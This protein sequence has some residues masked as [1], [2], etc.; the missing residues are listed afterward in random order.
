M[1]SPSAPPLTEP[2]TVVIDADRP[3]AGVS[4]AELWRYRDLLVILA[5]RDLQ[6]RYRQA[7]I[8][9]GWAVLR[10]AATVAIFV[11]F[12]G[13]LGKLPASGT[14]SYAASALVGFLSWQLVAATISHLSD[15]LVNN[16]HVLTKVYFPRVLI[17][18]S[19]VSVGLVDYLVALIPTVG[20]LVFLGVRS[21][22]PL[23]FAPLWLA[24]LLSAAIGTGLL[25]SALNA[26]YRDIGQLVPFLLQL[27]FFL[28]PVVYE[29][30]AIIPERWLWLY[31][32]NPIATGLDGLRWSLLG[33]PFPGGMST[34]TAVVI[35]AVGFQF[36]WRVFHQ[37]DATLADRI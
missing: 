20:L 37:L 23:L 34:M 17:P 28:C 32:L 7:V 36:S 27:G 26:R 33:T 21:G 2:I 15:S 31:R 14:A 6:V 1:T 9:I 8:G 19:A 11:T 16:R 24:G 4:L 10:P 3:E 12:F 5:L 30:T 13:L 29:T 25:F 22:W 18:L 35:V